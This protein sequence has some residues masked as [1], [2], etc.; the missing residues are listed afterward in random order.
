M[1]YFD[2]YEKDL[3]PVIQMIED[4]MSHANGALETAQANLDAARSRCSQAQA[5]LDNACQP[6]T[7]EVEVVTGRSV[8]S[9]SGNDIVSVDTQT[10]EVATISADA[11]SGA[12]ES[13]REAVREEAV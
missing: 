11:V 8:E 6:S 5:D 7:E 13:Y 3:A 9:V 12:V 4:Q 2:T 10:K 1:A